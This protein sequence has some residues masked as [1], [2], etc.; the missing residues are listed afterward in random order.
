MKE[1]RIDFS[2]DELDGLRRRIDIARLPRE[3]K[4]TGWSYGTD[5][6]YL[7]KLLAYWRD[8]YDWR[9][10]E[11]ELNRYPQFTCELDGTT[12]HFFHI[13]SSRKNAPALLLTHGWPDSLLRYAKLSP[14][15]QTIIL[16]YPRCEGVQQQR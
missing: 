5:S 13:R 10:R 11:R 14:C 1:F 16:S 7:R 4:G 8:E 2:Q 3:W 12:I 6:D 15:C 9:H